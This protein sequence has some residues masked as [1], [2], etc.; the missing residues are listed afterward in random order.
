VLTGKKLRNLALY[1]LDG[2]PWEF[3]NR[4]GRLVL[5]DFWGTWCPPCV[6]AIPVLNILQEKYGRHGLEVIGIAYEWGSPRE[7]VEK[8]E[9][10]SRL[11][12]IQYRVL[13]GGG[14]DTVCPVRHQF[15]VSAY[16][17]LVLLDEDGMIL[18]R[19]DQGLDA[20]RLQDLELLL[21]QKLRTARRN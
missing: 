17:T 12:R 3:R 6:Q 1:G 13:L 9:R 4:Q 21:G 18:W 16:P 11:K 2:Q 20:S 10:V 5:L 14:Y 19:N 15:D 8:V 7:Q